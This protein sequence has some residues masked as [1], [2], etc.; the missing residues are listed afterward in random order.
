MRRAIGATRRPRIVVAVVV[1]AGGLLAACGSGPSYSGSTTTTGAPGSL[2]T[3]LRTAA[4]TGL[5]TVVVDARGFTVYVLSSGSGN[6]PC[7]TANGCAAIWPP[8][9]VPSGAAVHA[10]AGIRSA[11]L[12]TQHSGNATFATYHGWRMYEF[13]GDTGPGQSGGQGLTSYGGTWHAID[14]FGQLVTTV[15]TPTTPTTSYPGY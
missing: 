2:G 3:T 10:G 13:S 12:G 11:L 4:V 14:R 7:T 15:S 6:L 1:A 8:V 9:R 5:G